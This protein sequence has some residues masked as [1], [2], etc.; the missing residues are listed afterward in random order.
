[1]SKTLFRTAVVFSLSLVAIGGQLTF[2]EPAPERDAGRLYYYVPDGIDLSRPAPLLV[3][4]HGGGIDSTDATAGSY[5]SAERRALMPDVTNAPFI[6]A[7]PSAP[8]TGDSSRWNHAGASKLI[9]DTI[10][11]ASRKFRIDRDRI[12]LGGHSMGCYGRAISGRYWPTG[13]PAC[14]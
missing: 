10:A 7:A 4:L 14:G 9:D 12:F 1:M 6:V 5:F 3:F 8:V 2:D 11:A 13:S